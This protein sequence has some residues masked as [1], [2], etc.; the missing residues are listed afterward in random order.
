MKYTRGLAWGLLGLVL[1]RVGFAF[2]PVQ[3][4]YSSG[5]DRHPSWSPNGQFIVFESNRSG[6]WRIYSIHPDGT[7]EVQLTFGPEDQAHPE[8]SP[9]GTRL[10]HVYGYMDPSNGATISSGLQIVPVGGGVPVTLVPNTGKVVWHPTWSSTGEYV[11]F[12][13][14]DT[15]WNIYRV[16]AAGGSP[17]L[18][19]DIDNEGLSSISP[20]NAHLAY[21]LGLNHGALNI[22][23]AP[24]SDPMHYKFLTSETKNTVP[25]DYSPDGL[26][27]VYTS[28]KIL[29]K[30]ELFELDLL[31]GVS[32]RLTF[33]AEG[34]SGDPTNHLADYSP[35]GTAVVFSSMRVTREENLWILPL[36]APPPPTR[37]VPPSRQV[38]RWAALNERGQPL[39]S[40]FYLAV[41]EAAGGR[42]V[43][44]LT[45]LRSANDATRTTRQ[46]L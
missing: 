28:R 17:V 44:R 11:Y 15:D 21:E 20:D 30:L 42:S 6:R 38:R 3:V 27:M 7:N 10:V 40:G 33:D 37:T 19:V 5:T 13:Q 18:V 39:P 22:A 26:R 12:D 8:I 23:Q 31:T 46:R 41:V 45:H 43:I 32:T 25:D 1:P 14:V 16:P 24:L 9:D 35:D 34:T 2:E 29:G 36:V 4:T